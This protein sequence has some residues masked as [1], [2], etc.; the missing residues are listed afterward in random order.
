MEA[1][2][3]SDNSTPHRAAEYDAEILSTIPFYRQFHAE[4]IDV[5]RTLLPGV[6]V[7][8][9]T[10]CG[11]GYLAEQALPLFPR[12]LF[13]LAD[14]AQAMLDLARARLARFPS[15][16]VRFLDA[17]GSEGLIGVVPETP[18][19]ISA[20]QCHHYGGEEVRRLATS[21]CFRLLKPGGVYVTF[22]NIRPDTPRGIEIGLDRWLRFQREAGRSTRAVEEHRSRFD[23]NYFPITVSEHLE[24]LRMAGFTTVEL[25]WLSHM[26]AGFYA[27]K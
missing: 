26:Q 1:L 7:W 20:I 24:L 16:R 9:D 11:T 10:G 27:I 25:F 6:S 3:M 22:E 13:L 15:E 18:Q 19:V 12:A 4:T 21:A 2:A 5:V 8:L 14:P 23:R 17:V